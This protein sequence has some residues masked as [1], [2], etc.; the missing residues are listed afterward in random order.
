MLHERSLR[1]RT[2][3]A[4]IMMTIALPSTMTACAP[5]VGIDGQ[6]PKP[7]KQPKRTT[8]STIPDEEAD[9]GATTNPGP[10]RPACL[11]VEAFVPRTSNP[12]APVQTGACTTAQIDALAV[13]VGA[14][15][16]AECEAARSDTPG[17][18][19][20]IFSQREEPTWKV[21]VA[22]PEG[23]H[24]NQAGCVEH[25]TKDPGCGDA[26]MTVAGCYSHHCGTCSEADSLACVDA[27]SGAECRAFGIT[28]SCKQAL[29]DNQAAVDGCFPTSLTPEGVTALFKSMAAVQCP[30]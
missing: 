18:A 16:S 3:F 25:V 22:G 30:P 27:A 10:V 7:V 6:G 13:C 29:E 17:C 5:D 14:M 1:G 8:D 9:A 4:L 15:D 11:L 23:A 12:P 26:F 28:A 20:C 24:F 21:I 19:A 2:V